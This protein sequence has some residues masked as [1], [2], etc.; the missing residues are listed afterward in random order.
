MEEVEREQNM[1][2]WADDDG[3]EQFLM[4]SMGATYKLDDEELNLVK[5]PVQDGEARPRESVMVTVEQDSEI[6]DHT[7]REDE[8]VPEDAV[9]HI[10]GWFSSIN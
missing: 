1:S 2:L 7:E 9:E 10:V 6:P 5:V 3:E 4:F 8:T